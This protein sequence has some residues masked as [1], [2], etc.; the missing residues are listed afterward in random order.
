MGKTTYDG[1]IKRKQK[2]TTALE[3]YLKGIPQN[4]IAELVQVSDE[5]ITRWKRE[6]KWEEEYQRRIQPAITA[7]KSIWAIINHNLD[8][9]NTAI[10]GQRKDGALS[11]IT[12]A[13]VQGITMLLGKVKLDKITPADIAKVCEDLLEYLRKKKPDV[14]KECSDAVI[15]FVRHKADIEH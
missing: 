9:I 8:C 6:D 7:E 2:R 5:S 3:L 10:E 1:T 14:A 11:P 13:E 12:Y 4:R 15:E